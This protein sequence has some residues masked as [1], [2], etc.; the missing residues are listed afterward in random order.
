M[1]GHTLDRSP[2][3]ESAHTDRNNKTF[4]QYKNKVIKSV[5]TESFG[6]L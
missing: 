3:Y 1:G 6:I 4:L 5:K 2:A